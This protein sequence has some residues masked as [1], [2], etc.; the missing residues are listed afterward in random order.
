MKDNSK[1]ITI[2]LSTSTWSHCF[3]GIEVNLGSGLNLRQRS[4]IGC[5]SKSVFTVHSVPIS[6]HRIE[7]NQ[8][9]N[10]MS[11]PLKFMSSRMSP[12]ASQSS[13]PY[14]PS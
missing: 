13:P 4:Q 3:V 2:S 11:A 6:Y 5:F 12:R 14:T 10:S 9:S 1:C 8:K 7:I